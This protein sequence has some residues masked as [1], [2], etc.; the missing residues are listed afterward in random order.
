MKD[1]ETEVIKLNQSNN[2]AMIIIKLN[3]ESIL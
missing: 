2:F 1:D 3:Y